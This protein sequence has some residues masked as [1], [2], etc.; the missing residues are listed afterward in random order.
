LRKQRVSKPDAAAVPGF[1]QDANNGIAR[2]IQRTVNTFFPLT[3]TE[4]DWNTA[5]YRLEDY[6]RSLRI[7]S[8]VHQS[9]IILHL[10]EKAASR[11][12]NEP[13]RNPTELAMEEAR[14]AMEHWF[15]TSLGQRDRLAVTGLISLLAI[16]APKKWPV[17]FLSDEVPVEFRQEMKDSDVRAGPDLQVSSMVPRPIDVG[18]L[19]DPLHFADALVKVKWSM[20][21]VAVATLAALSLSFFYLMH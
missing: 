1:A 12:A 21:L 14:A 6:F 11:H 2:E 3:G 9:Q 13:S 7:V 4:A 18:P 19:L 16:D 15:E 20:A 8:K 17:A 5:Y 10:L